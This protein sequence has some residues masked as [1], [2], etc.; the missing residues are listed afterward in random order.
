MQGL[1]RKSH[2]TLR[3]CKRYITRWHEK[4]MHESVFDFSFLDVLKLNVVREVFCTTLWY[5]WMHCGIMNFTT[6]FEH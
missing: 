5:T 2:K 3:L 4:G 6:G 1:S